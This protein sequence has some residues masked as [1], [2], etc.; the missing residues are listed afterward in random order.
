MG[1]GL[2]C[3]VWS[4]AN[5][6]CF[7]RR[8]LHHSSVQDKLGIRTASRLPGSI[9]RQSVDK[10]LWTFVASQLNIIGTKS[11]ITHVV[12]SDLK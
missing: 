3:D 8:S 2:S 11:K 12:R 5:A 9:T 6:D 1:T 7:Q 10:E 4:D